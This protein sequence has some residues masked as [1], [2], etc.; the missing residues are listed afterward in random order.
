MDPRKGSELVVAKPVM[1]PLQMCLQT[2]RI[3]SHGDCQGHLWMMKRGNDKRCLGRCGGGIGNERDEEGLTGG[4]DPT[5]EV[6]TRPARL[7]CQAN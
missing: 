6:F 3:V 7:I 2:V 5:T 4:A 1:G